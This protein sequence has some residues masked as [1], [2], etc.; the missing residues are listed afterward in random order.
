MSTDSDPAATGRAPLSEGAKAQEDSIKHVLG[1]FVGDE[2]PPPEPPTAETKGFALGEAI[3]RLLR[4]TPLDKDA[5]DIDER[6]WFRQQIWRMFFV[7]ALC[8]SLLVLG[9][10]AIAV[11]RMVLEAPD[12]E[13][14][15]TAVD[16]AE[17]DTGQPAAAAGNRWY[18]TNSAGLGLYTIALHGDGVSGTVD[19]I[20]DA[21]DAGTFTWTGDTL[22]IEFTRKLTMDDGYVVTDP[23]RFECAGTRDSSRMDC[24]TTVQQWAYS[25]RD[26]FEVQGENTWPSVAVPR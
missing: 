13:P 20:E 24:T 4:P 26:G 11:A 12:D 10:A 23:W 19:V 22:T 6:I 3:R 5:D 2:P 8:V 16:D 21:T 17:A 1:H 15:A 14:I 9:V 25:G 18:F 7:A